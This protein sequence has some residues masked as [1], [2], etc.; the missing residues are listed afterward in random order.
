[1]EYGPFNLLTNNNDKNSRNLIYSYSTK[2]SL[3]VASLFDWWIACLL[4]KG[5]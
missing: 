3:N 2:P 4:K 5:L 1:M